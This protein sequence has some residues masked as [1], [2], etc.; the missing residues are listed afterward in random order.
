MY[1]SQSEMSIVSI[2]F[3]YGFIHR[4]GVPLFI[5]VTYS[6]QKDCVYLSILLVIK[7]T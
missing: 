5:G 1:H 4:H 2:V 3:L 6:H 7:K